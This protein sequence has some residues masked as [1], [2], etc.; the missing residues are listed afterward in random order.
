[1]TAPPVP[2]FGGKQQIAARLVGMLPPHHHY[3]EPFAGGLS[4]LLAKRRSR[5]ETVNDL[6]GELMTWWRMLRDQPDELA[7]ACALTPHSR[8]E[9]L[10]AADRPADLDDIEIARRVWVRL[11]QGRG[12]GLR[13]GG[14]RHHI[15]PNGTGS[16]MPVYLRGYV[17]RMAPAAARLAGVSLESRPA[18]D[19][20]S[21]Y[22]H[23][24]VLFYVD[25]PY[26]QDTRS[27]GSRYRYEMTDADHVDLLATLRATAAAVVLSGYATDLYD[28]TLADWHRVE[29][30]AGTGQGSIWK[31]RTEVVWSNR[32]LHTTSALFEVRR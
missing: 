23:P 11:T 20:I 22:N 17:A 19:L 1:M 12:M 7:R 24:D 4:V 2:Y 28:S 29:I 32:P 21:S 27:G 16:A 30:A 5:C 18:L 13:H 6:D 8:A 25:P 9:Y 10:A 14:W 3:V 15:D 26:V 31:D